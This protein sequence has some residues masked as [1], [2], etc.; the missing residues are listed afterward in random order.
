MA[1]IPRF[2]AVADNATNPTSAP[3]LCSTRFL[4]PTLSFAPETQDTMIITSELEYS[5]PEALFYL[6]VFISSLFLTASFLVCVLYIREK[7]L[8]LR[9]LE[10]FHRAAPGKKTFH[11]VQCCIMLDDHYQFECISC[12]ND[13][14]VGKASLQRYVQCESEKPLL[15]SEGKIKCPL[16]V[17]WY[18]DQSLAMFCEP[19]TYKCYETMKRNK[20]HQDQKAN[21]LAEMEAN[22]KAEEKKILQEAIRNQFR[23]G[24]GNYYGLKCPKCA[25]GPV[26]HME[27]GDLEAHH[28]EEKDYGVNINNSCPMCFWFGESKTEWGIWDGE[29]L[30]GIQLEETQAAVDEFKLPFEKFKDESLLRLQELKRLLMETQVCNRMALLQE[31]APKEL[32]EVSESASYINQAEDPHDIM[33]DL[34]IAYQPHERNRLMKHLIN[35]MKAFQTKK[36]AKA[37]ELN[38]KALKKEQTEIDKLLAERRKEMEAGA[39]AA[40]AALGYEI[41]VEHPLPSDDEF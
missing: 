9:L 40:V 6:A 21:V 30:D 16:C 14:F 24:D 36:W 41:E 29:F 10:V 19:E 28:E 7:V 20:I 2:L 13:H 25:F 37:S 33:Y 12:P 38:Y 23:I 8:R 4:T 34:Q 27:C 35:T 31:I 11:K 39:Q 26:D 22:E 3:F 18:D 5:M 32:P 1:Y 17:S 15:K